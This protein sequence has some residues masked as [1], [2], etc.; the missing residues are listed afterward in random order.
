MRI[1]FPY[2]DIYKT[3]NKS[4]TFN[5]SKRATSCL[6]WNVLRTTGQEQRVLTVRRDAVGGLEDSVS[7]VIEQEV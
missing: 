6:A 3:P 7:K 1:I 5:A 2:T 4:G